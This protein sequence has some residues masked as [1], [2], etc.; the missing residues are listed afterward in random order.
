MTPLAPPTSVQPTAGPATAPTVTAPNSAPLVDKVDT[1]I[2]ANST[3]VNVV[4]VGVGVAVSVGGATALFLGLFFGL[5]KLD[6]KKKAKAAAAQADSPRPTE[7]IYEAVPLS[8]SAVTASAP[9]STVNSMILSAQIKL[10]REIGSGNYGKVY[11]AKFNNAKVA[12][13]FYHQIEALQDFQHEADL[14][15]K[16]KPHPN[17]VQLIG[18]CT[19]G[20]QPAIILEYCNGGSLDKYLKANPLLS[21]EEKIKLMYGTACGICHLHINDIVHRD[22]A[23]RNILLNRGQPK[24]SVSSGLD[25]LFGR[26]FL[27][28]RCRTLACHG[29]LHR[30]KRWARPRPTLAPS[31]GCLPSLSLVKYIRQSQVRSERKVSKCHNM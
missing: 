26:H 30:M 27:T 2:V 9:Q 17:I 22:L 12:V 3:E 8:T 16:M 11:I 18:I 13:K 7:T 24:I 14:F 29:S 1:P 5:K 21:D 4:D 6:K 25:P 19:D 23:A 15:C 10:D 28:S 20:T 31:S